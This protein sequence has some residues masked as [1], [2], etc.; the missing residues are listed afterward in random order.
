MVFE[1]HL[2]VDELLLSELPKNF[3]SLLVLSHLLLVLQGETLIDL[4]NLEHEH[5]ASE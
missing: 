5:R 3:K 4:R 2:Q 1:V